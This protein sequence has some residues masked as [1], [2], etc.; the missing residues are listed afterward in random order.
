M[1]IVETEIVNFVVVISLNVVV[2]IAVLSYRCYFLLEILLKVMI[3]DSGILILV[4][5]KEVNN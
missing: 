4:I 2:V 5:Y 1:F 3:F